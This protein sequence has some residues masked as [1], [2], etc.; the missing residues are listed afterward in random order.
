MDLDRGFVIR[1]VQIRQ[2]TEYD[3]HAHKITPLFPEERQSTKGIS[4]TML[5]LPFKSL[6][7]NITRLIE[8]LLSYYLKATVT[9]LFH[10]PCGHNT[11]QVYYLYSSNFLLT[12][13]VQRIAGYLVNMA[14]KQSQERKLV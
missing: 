3:F 10:W 2:D 14:E 5:D 6:T 13:A 9:L 1:G 12:Y 7:D 11:P 4:E 8:F